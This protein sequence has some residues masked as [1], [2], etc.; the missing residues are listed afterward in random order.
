MRAI[1]MHVHVPR[2]PG[3]PDI[4]VE[5]EMRRYFRVKWVPESVD[6]MAAK[7]KEWDLLGVVFSIDNETTTGE[8]PDS[9]DYLAEIVRRYP[10]QFVGFAGV[11]PWK[12]ELGVR[13][14]ERSIL[15]LGLKGLKL[16]PVQQAFFPN[17]SRFYPLYEKCVELG[18]PVLF[19]SG[20]AAAGLGTP[21]GAGL[22]LKYAAPIPGMDD[23]AAD[24][25]ELTVIMAHPAWPW[26]EEQIAV[27][28]HKANVYLDLSG[29]SP[30]YIPEALIRE[31][32]SR[33]Q[34]K[35]LFGS[36]FPYMPPDRWLQEFQQLP[37]REEV[38][39]K[40][41]SENAERVLGLSGDPAA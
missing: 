38:R 29:W 8:P 26:I 28:L 37:I 35:V 21:G 34:D 17:D 27:A 7:Y 9:N 16:H 32:G 30:K 3:L 36:D 31:A 40:I 22:K 33:L 25:P 12:G 18:V 15:E 20:L 2:Q 23:V 4:A 5:E 1:D 13:E 11:D 6:E 14:L 19:H 10:E 41:L 39:S 24:F